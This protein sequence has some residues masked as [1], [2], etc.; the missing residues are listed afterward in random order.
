[1]AE[2]ENSL[3]FI[4]SC[5]FGVNVILIWTLRN[6]LNEYNKASSSWGHVENGII[7]GVMN[8]MLEC[9]CDSWYKADRLQRAVLDIQ[10]DHPETT[11]LERLFRIWGEVCYRYMS[12]YWARLKLLTDILLVIRKYCGFPFHLSYLNIIFSE[13]NGLCCLRGIDNFCVLSKR[14][15]DEDGG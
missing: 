10:R 15:G 9:G 1:M 8:D 11:T 13:L 6:S 7:I 12:V 14:D 5:H 3:L 2:S 4:L